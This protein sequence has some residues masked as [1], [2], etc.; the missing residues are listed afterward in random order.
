MRELRLEQLRYLPLGEWAMPEEDLSK[1][2]TLSE[3]ESIVNACPHCP[4]R[5]TRTNVVFGVGSPKANLLFIGEAPGFHEDQTGEPF[6]GAAGRLLDEL[7]RSVLG[8][9]RSDIYIANVLKC[10]PPGNRDPLPEEI[11]HCLPFLRKQVELIDPK[12]ICTLGKHAGSV[13]MRENISISKIHGVPLRMGKRTLFPTYHPAA[14]LYNGS[15][16]TLLIE[17][18]HVLKELLE[19]APVPAPESDGREEQMDLLG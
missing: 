19:A 14:G 10:R 12:V 18:F 15:T 13:V 3:L 11:E 17:D 6:V 8:L 5:E 4:L 9:S 1:V 7:T 16:K 2:K